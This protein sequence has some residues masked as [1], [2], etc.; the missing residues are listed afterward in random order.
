MKKTDLHIG[1]H[2]PL[3]PEDTPTQTYGCR[4]YNPDICANAD[5]QKIC[6]FVRPDGICKR[7]PRTWKKQYKIL[8]GKE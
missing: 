5:T 1:V 7:P 4:A 3:R 8:G 6:A 2:S